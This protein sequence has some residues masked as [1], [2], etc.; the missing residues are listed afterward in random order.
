MFWGWGTFAYFNP[1]IK[2]GIIFWR[3]STNICYVFTLQKRIIT[4]IS[5]VGAKNTCRNLFV[6][7]DILPVSCQYILSLLMLMVDN[8]KNYQTGLPVHGLNTRTRISCICLLLIFCVFREVFPTLLWR[9]LLLYQII[10]RILGMTDCSLNL[11]YV[12]ILFL[13]HFIR[14]HNSLSIIEIIHIIDILNF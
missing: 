2:F 4:I 11:C 1:I 8:L 7:P 9:S 5:G 14:W 3:N 13:V 6:K 10:S 12:I